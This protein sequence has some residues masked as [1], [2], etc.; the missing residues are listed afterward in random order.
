MQVDQ[1]EQKVEHEV[2]ETSAL[3]LNL[4]HDRPVCKWFRP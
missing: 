4:P 3:A 2:P 1:V